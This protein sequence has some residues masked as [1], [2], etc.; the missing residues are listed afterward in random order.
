[1]EIKESGH[2]EIMGERV[3]KGMLDMKLKLGFSIGNE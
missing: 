1:M 2:T 3:W